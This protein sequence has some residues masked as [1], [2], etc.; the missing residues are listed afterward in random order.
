M[1]ILLLAAHC[2]RVQVDVYIQMILVDH[3]PTCWPN[4]PAM[5]HVLHVLVPGGLL[6]LL[7]L[8]LLL[9]LS[10]LLLLLLL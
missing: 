1:L 9:L 10:L 6:R 3:H 2:Q 4:P 5:A 8:L 7:W